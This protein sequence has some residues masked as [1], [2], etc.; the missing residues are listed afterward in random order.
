[1]GTLG[2]YAIVGRLSQAR[3][4]QALHG[5]VR[6]MVLDTCACVPG[7]VREASVVVQDGAGH[8]TL[9]STLSVHPDDMPA[10][11]PSGLPPT[12]LCTCLMRRAIR[13][14]L[15]GIVDLERRRLRGRLSQA[16]GPDR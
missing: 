10:G 5:G 6:V 9:V 16:T 4:M 8:C 14:W 12:D 15:P 13:I 3:C 2:G 11:P 1:V 7:A